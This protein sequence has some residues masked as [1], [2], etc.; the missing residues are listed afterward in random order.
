MIALIYSLQSKFKHAALYLPSFLPSFLPPSYLPSFLLI[1][2]IQHS[3]KINDN[4]TKTPT[5]AKKID[6][7]KN[8]SLSM[9]VKMAQ[10]MYFN[11]NKC[12]YMWIIELYICQTRYHCIC[13]SSERGSRALHIY[14][15]ETEWEKKKEPK[16]QLNCLWHYSSSR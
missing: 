14:K 7:N 9:R 11:L 5:I 15:R 2:S 4:N 6:N 1:T 3:N 12:A 16:I 8:I 10:K 13:V